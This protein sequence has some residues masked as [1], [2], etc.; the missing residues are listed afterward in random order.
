LIGSPRYGSGIN[1]S[2]SMNRLIACAAFAMLAALPAEAGRPAKGVVELF[3][4]QGCS[5]CPPADAA[6]STVIGAGGVVAL[7]WHVDYWDYLGWKDTFSS[8]TAT[9]RQEVYARRIGGGSYTP[10]FVVNGRSGSSSSIAM[11]SGGLPVS[12]SVS[13]GEAKIGEGQGTAN[14]FLVN[15]TPS[16][17]VPIVRGENAGRSVTYRHIVTSVKNLGEWNG[18]A[19]TLAAGSG[20]CAVILQRPGQ[21][22]IIGAAEC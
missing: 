19:L 1:R 20:N 10:E 14:V 15:Y 5:S 11:D 9:A 16:A 12:V 13:G 4:S 17:T 21:G 7:A 18:K 22:E 2:L 8:H 6:L 3:T